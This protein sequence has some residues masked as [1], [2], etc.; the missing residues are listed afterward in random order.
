MSELECKSVKQHFD[1]QNCGVGILDKD[2]TE[3]LLCKACQT[4]KI[5][6]TV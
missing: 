3:L 5:S 4:P 1:C 6:H 2:L